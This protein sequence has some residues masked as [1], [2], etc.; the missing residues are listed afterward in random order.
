M[1]QLIFLP[2]LASDA[3]MWQ[4]QI[5]ALRASHA[6]HVTDVHARHGRIEDMAAALL[7]EHPGELVLCGA[8]MGG[9]VAMEVARQAPTRIAGLALLGTNARPETDDM[10]QLR[11]GAIQFFEKGRMEEVL[12]ANLPFAFHPSRGRD[13]ALTG[14]YLAFVQQAGPRQLIRQ[15]RA[16]MERPDARLHLP[17][18]PCPVLVMC[19]DTD[20]LTPPECSREIA[21]LLPRAELQM[22]PECGHMLTMERPEIVSAALQDWLERLALRPG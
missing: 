1:P 12:R 21:A 20:R 22:V 2:G 14:S 7:A 17:S 9:I 13:T 5:A 16:L 6:P 3:T 8:S 18:L 19:G 15:N 10:R 11:E 4:H